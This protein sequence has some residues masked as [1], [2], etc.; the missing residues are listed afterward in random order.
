MTTLATPRMAALEALLD[1]REE[2]PAFDDAQ[3]SALTAHVVDAALSNDDQ[4]LEAAFD[5][6]QWMSSQL[7]EEV[8]DAVEF[9]SGRVRGVLDVVRWHLRRSVTAAAAAI[10]SDGLAARMLRFVSDQ[11]GSRNRQIA[12]FLDVDET[13]VSR[14]GRY[15]RESALASP[16]RV[17]RENAWFVSPRGA[18]CLSALSAE[19]PERAEQSPVAEEPVDVEGRE[20]S[21]GVAQVLASILEN[22][23]DDT[24]SVRDAT[25]LPADNVAK[26]IEFLMTRGYVV[27]EP[28]GPG[29]RSRLKV[30]ERQHRALG[31]SVREGEVVGVLADLRANNVREDRIGVDVSDVD[32]LIDAVRSLCSRLQGTEPVPADIVGLGVNL[33]GHV[34]PWHGRVVYSPLGSSP[35]WRNLQLVDRLQAATGLPTTVENDVNALALYEKYFGTGQGLSDFAVVSVTAD[36]EGIGSGLVV[37][38]RLVHG[39]TGS[40]GEIGH[41]PISTHE[42]QCRCSNPGCL[43]AAVSFSAM[44]EKFRRAGIHPPATL[45][46]ASA[47][48]GRGDN[49]AREKFAEAGQAFGLGVATI[50]NT[51]DPE[52]LIL[53]GPREVI[54]D[55][56]AGA[57]SARAFTQAARDTLHRHAFSNTGMHCRIEPKLLTGVYAARGAASALLLQRLYQSTGERPAPRRFVARAARA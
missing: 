33:P 4:V 52:L 55:D 45:S 8:G 27:R 32:Q 47:W 5:G 43:E 40:A 17:G 24:A 35:E 48:A 30:N 50:L 57:T 56:G 25:G 21:G 53:S 41:A 23:P 2:S 16:R 22:E 11:P 3:W 18:A 51:L 34:D 14:V 13:Q 31:V 26:A 12:T 9:E 36:G 39:S 29:T 49:F 54:D 46:E 44:Q 38:G 1:A 15:L 20:L 42:R 7:A 19:P 10:P 6:L 37:G 28:E